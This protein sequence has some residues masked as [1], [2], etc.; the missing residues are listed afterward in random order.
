[1]KVL[2]I[3]NVQHRRKLEIKATDVVLFGPVALRNDGSAFKN[4]V[5]QICVAMVAVIAWYAYK[6]NQKAQQQVGKLMAHVESLQQAERELKSLQE[7]LDGGDEVDF[8]VPE[9]VCYLMGC[10]CTKYLV[11]YGT[12]RGLGGA[13]RHLSGFSAQI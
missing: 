8:E 3:V 6:V 4:P 7:R 5:V 12:V 2:G 13:S 11:H 1:M 10:G 9:R